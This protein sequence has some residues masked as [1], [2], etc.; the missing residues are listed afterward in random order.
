LFTFEIGVSVPD[1]ESIPCKSSSKDIVNGLEVDDD[2]KFGN[3]VFKNVERNSS[4]VVDGGGD[5]GG[6]SAA[7]TSSVL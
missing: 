3:K 1:E 4:D 6:G 2:P 5:G 7:E